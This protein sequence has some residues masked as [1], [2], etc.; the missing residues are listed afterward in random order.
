M[1]R[2]MQPGEEAILILI[3]AAFVIFS[4]AMAYATYLDGHEG[5]EG[6]RKSKKK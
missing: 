4:A 3:I 5:R 1:E 2:E 6:S